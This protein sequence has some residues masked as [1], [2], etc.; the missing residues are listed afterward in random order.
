MGEEPNHMMAR[1]PRSSKNHS[2]LS[3][4]PD[5]FLVPSVLVYLSYLSYLFPIHNVRNVIIII[6]IQFFLSHMQGVLYSVHYNIHV[7]IHAFMDDL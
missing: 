3:G 4:L 7:H 1:K 6:K 2:I 5:P